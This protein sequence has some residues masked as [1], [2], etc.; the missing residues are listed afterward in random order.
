MASNPPGACCTKTN[1][2]EGT[3][4]GVFKH[5]YGRDTYETGTNK[6]RVIVIL[7]DIFGHNYNNV[8]L[9]ADELAKYDYYVIIPDILNND[10][11]SSSDD[12]SEWLVNHTPEIT[13]PIVDGFLATLKKELDPKFLGAIGYCFG[14]KYAVQNLTKSGP[15]N[16]AALAHP[17][18][19]SIE[20]VKAIG[21]PVIISAA[22]TD[23]IF[24]TELRH[25]TE[26]ALA[27]LKTVRY[28]I[29]LFSGV[30]HGYACR[31]DISDPSVKYAKEKTLFDQVSFFDQF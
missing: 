14:A 25:E 21:N 9:I 4:I 28:Q 11:L 1:F 24:T 16:A 23:D 30:S 12:F 20:E 2:H 8:M 29:S 13:T 31:G 7:T 6:K 3:P 17:S 22:E 26:L 5:Q 18:F 15:L 10:P 19:V 27:E